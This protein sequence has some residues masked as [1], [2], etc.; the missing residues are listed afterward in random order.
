MLSIDLP[1]PSRV[2]HPNARSHYMA[3]AK[4][5]KKARADAAWIAKA[6]G[7]RRSDPDIP[8]FLKV[9]IIFCPPDNR[10]RD[11][12]GML[13][14]LKSALDGIADATGV[15][16]SKWEIALRR[17]APVKGGLVRIQIEDASHIAR[18]AVAWRNERRVAEI[19]EIVERASGVCNG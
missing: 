12:D 1:W 10:R 6:A 14:S 5:A 8:Q 9:T 17:E 16:D 11:L 18:S 7:I 15:D 2:L 3:K 19:D 4:V 13:S